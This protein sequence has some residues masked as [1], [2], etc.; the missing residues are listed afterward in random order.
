MLELSTHLRKQAGPFDTLKG[1]A[2]STDIHISTNYKLMEFRL[3]VRQK[4][5]D[6]FA[7]IGAP[8]TRSE[9]KEAVTGKSTKEKEKVTLHMAL[10][11]YIDAC[12]NKEII[13][14][15]KPLS[16]NTKRNKI[17]NCRTL[18]ASCSD[19]TLSFVLSKR[20]HRVESGI[21]RWEGFGE[22]I[23]SNL[24]GG[25]YDS[26]S[27]NTFINNLKSI[28]RWKLKK[29]APNN[30]QFIQRII[31]QNV[32]Y[33]VETL[34]SEDTEYLVTNQSKLRMKLTSTQN[35]AMDY[36]LTAL[37]LAPRVG[38]M[39]K[40]D[41]SNLYEKDGKHWLTYVQE[42]TGVKIDVPINTLVHSIFSRN[43]ISWKSLLPP[44]PSILNQSITVICSLIPSM[45]EQGSKTRIRGGKIT[46]IRK[47]R[48]QMISIHRMRATSITN[49]LDAG[50]PTHIVKSYS[51]HT[52]DSKAFARYVKSRDNAKTK[53]SETYIKS[54]A[55]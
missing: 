15:G 38:D 45:Q 29:I 3:M 12:E 39:K 36:L 41:S 51:G 13:S 14:N 42:K 19:E 54:I 32:R 18:I 11:E 1:Y 25:D 34:T 23:I 46:E 17:S 7:D 27:I 49:M 55:I 33:E 5:A 9:L 22:D 52:G 35:H 37:F 2:M 16:A 40:W 44:C 21:A 6:L 30:I 26:S 8:P 31:F 53:A 24:L 10:L 20:H 4:Y 47:P 50:I 43:L 48:W 28:L